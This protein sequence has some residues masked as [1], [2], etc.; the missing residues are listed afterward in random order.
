MPSI[1]FICQ[2][3][4]CRSPMAAALFKQ[5]ISTLPDAPE[6]QVES[7]GTWGLDGEPAAA[8]VQDLLSQRGLDIS[9]HHA[10]SVSGSLLSS[11]DLVLAME[12]GQVEGM[13][14]EFPPERDRIFLISEMVG[15]QYEIADP[16]GRGMAAFEETA[17]E[18]EVIFELGFERMLEIA[19]TNAKNDAIS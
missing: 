13:R 14:I 11:A 17:Q 9:Q 1:L 4:I 15:A 16:Y 5:R 19:R 18:L 8:Q 3:N 7:A 12:K 2:A 6:W 10:R